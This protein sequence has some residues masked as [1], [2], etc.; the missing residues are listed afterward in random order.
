VVGEVKIKIMNEVGRNAALVAP[1]PHPKGT[2]FN[3]PQLR[4]FSL[5]SLW[6]CKV[7]KPRMNANEREFLFALIGG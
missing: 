2:K 4:D 5:C 7:F 1:K 3:W 6:W